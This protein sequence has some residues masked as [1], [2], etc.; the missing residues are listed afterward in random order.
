MPTSKANTSGIHTEW[1]SNVWSAEKGCL[2][3]A[4]NMGQKKSHPWKKKE[5]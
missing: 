1:K 5:N 3:L 2:S 4:M